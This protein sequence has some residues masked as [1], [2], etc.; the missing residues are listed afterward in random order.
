[1][2]ILRRVMAGVMIFILA[3]PIVF[4][5]QSPPI[6]PPKGP[7]I[8][9]PGDR[10]WPDWLEETAKRLEKSKAVSQQGSELEFLNARA[11]ELLE[12]A[13]SSRDNYFRFGRYIAAANAMLEASDRIVWLRKVERTPQEQDFWGAGFMLPGCYFRVRQ[14]EFFASLSGEKNGEQY[15]NWSKSFYQQARVALDAREYQRSRLYADASSFIVFAL[16]CIAQA[17]V[18]VPDAAK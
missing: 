14:A 17:V 3:V 7:D 15:V 16:E 5:V 1:M 6:Q 10:K 2:L 9:Q 8:W 13:K 12:R 18:Q 11:A 4:A